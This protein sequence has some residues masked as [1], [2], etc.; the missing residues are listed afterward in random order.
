MTAEKFWDREVSAPTHTSWMEHPLVRDYILE[1][2]GNGEKLWPVEWFM[3]ALGGRRFERALSV[4]CGT[5]PFER[6]IVRKNI[7]A[8]VDAFD[9][10]TNS[11][12]I[13][14]SLASAEGFSPR[15]RYFA[16]DFNEP[17][18]PRRTY[19]AVFIHQALHHVAKLEKLLR[20]ILLALRRGG[21]LY[22]DEYIGPSR[23]DWNDQRIAPLRSIFSALPP[24]A[25]RT[26]DL[27][28]PIQADDPSEAIRSSEILTQLAIG[29]DVREIRAYGGNV[30]SVLYP[31][32][33]PTAIEPLIA[34]EK[35]MLAAG[36][37]PYY[38]VI[39]ATPKRGVKKLYASLRYFAEP[40]LKRIG[41]E[42]RARFRPKPKP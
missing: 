24:G 34:E 15:I 19:D 38:A 8:R 29:F 41:R 9:G 31:A 28:L 23:H 18:L 32:V 17:S 22:L 13:A 37:A 26:G 12:R 5:G 36:A 16:A 33:D 40:K 42:I 39:V 25:R 2:I 7:A 6:D 10:S 27:P 30:L 11:L 21:V 4:G 14:A 3:R 20:S 35:R 1:S